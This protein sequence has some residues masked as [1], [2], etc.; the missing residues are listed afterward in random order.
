MDRREI[1][2]EDEVSPSEKI[3]QRLVGNGKNSKQSEM[4]GESRKNT[5]EEKYSAM[6]IVRQ[7]KAERTTPMDA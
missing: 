3:N 6:D 7:S 1:V 5:R 4:N 2:Y